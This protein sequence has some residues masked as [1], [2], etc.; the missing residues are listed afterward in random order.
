[1]GEVSPRA[2]GGVKAGGDATT[3]AA[4][5]SLGLRYPLPST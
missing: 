4:R 1:M 5:D 3:A 2:L